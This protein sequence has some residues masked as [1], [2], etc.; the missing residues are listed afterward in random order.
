MDVPSDTLG[1]SDIFEV[2]VYDER[3]LSGSYRVA[4]DGSIDF[5]LVGRVA[6]AGLT[7]TA[8]A[9]VLRNKLLRYMTNPQVSVFVKE[10][11][12][13]K[14]YVFGEV[15]KPGTFV[16][17]DGM[18]I[19]QA[20]TLAGGFDKLADQNGAFINR[21]VNGTET[22]IEVSVKDIG[23]AQAPNVELRPGDIVYI[24]ESMF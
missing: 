18:T 4:T 19:I 24:P 7:S 1:A 8:L 3:E 11:H 2:S 14:I 21:V 13:K 16:F 5:P 9:G 6:V 20:I 23:K 10:Y 22:R 15:R 17:E 12:S